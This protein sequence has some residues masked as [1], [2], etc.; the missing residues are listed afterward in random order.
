MSLCHGLTDG[1]LINSKLS[2]IE[3]IALFT[4]FNRKK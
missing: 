1:I 2:F 3:K 4:F